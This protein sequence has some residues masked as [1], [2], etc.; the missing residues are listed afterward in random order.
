MSKDSKATDTVVGV[1]V[2]TK[3][4]HHPMISATPVKDVEKKMGQSGDDDEDFVNVA[5][6]RF[7]WAPAN[8]VPVRGWL[9]NEL[10]MPAIKKRNWTAFLIRLTAPT[11]AVDRDDNNVDVPI[12]DEV[13]VPATHILRQALG[14]AATHPNDVYEVKIQ[15][16]A[17]SD[18]G[19][20]QSMWRYKVQAKANSKRRILFGL[21]AVLGADI[22]QLPPAELDDSNF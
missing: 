17:K 2:E 10:V 3:G 21:A 1:S 15:P 16:L 22:G 8:N 20:D 14:K 6:E 12:G 7:M 5:T 11:V 18:I 19:G 9:L 13:L 4:A